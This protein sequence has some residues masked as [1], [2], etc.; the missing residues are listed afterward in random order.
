MFGTI[1][2]RLTPLTKLTSEP[3]CGTSF[4][5]ANDN[6]GYRLQWHWIAVERNSMLHLFICTT[7]MVP[8]V[9]TTTTTFG[10]YRFPQPPS[11][12]SSPPFFPWWWGY[13]SVFGRVSKWL[14]YLLW[15]PINNCS[16]LIIMHM[17][18]VALDNLRQFYTSGIWYWINNPSYLVSYYMILY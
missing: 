8:P 5:G 17:F 4:R 3:S 11:V 9:T 12:H 18:Y 15:L 13:N 6:Y 10:C 1:S 14:T 16:L 7:K 2:L